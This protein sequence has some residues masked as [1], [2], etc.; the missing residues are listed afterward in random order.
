VE[1]TKENPAEERERSEEIAFGKKRKNHSPLSGRRGTLPG[2][3]K[4][5]ATKN[6]PL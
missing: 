3:K 2:K 4:G 6:N 5:S 1:G